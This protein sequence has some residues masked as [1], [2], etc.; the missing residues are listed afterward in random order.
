MVFL[1]AN[2]ALGHL[3]YFELSLCKSCCDLR[4]NPRHH[5]FLQW[6]HGPWH[7]FVN[8]VNVVTHRFLNTCCIYILEMVDKMD[9]VYESMLWYLFINLVLYVTFA[10]MIILCI[11]T[12]IIVIS[13]MNGKI[14]TA[15]GLMPCRELH[16]HS[17]MEVAT[18]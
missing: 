6:L 18:S 13:C 16:E 4:L 9:F 2:G 10:F 3:I 12:F 14:V 7:N 1:V 8:Y 5:H 17:S 11:V 15:N